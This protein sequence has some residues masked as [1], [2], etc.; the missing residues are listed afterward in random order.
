MFEIEVAKKDDLESLVALLGL[1][2]SKEAEF[3]PDPTLQRAGLEMILEDAT[4]GVIFVLK[5]GNQSI[6]MV[7]LLWTISTALG[8]KVA[9]LEDMMIHPSWQGK[10]GGSMLLAH[11]VSYAKTFT[12]KRITLLSDTDN[13]DAHRF[14]ERFGFTPSLMQ[15]M[16]LVLS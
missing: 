6:G 14:Y 3:A 9:L 10:G 13:H 11:A 7:S 1:L 8:G 5:E 2:F 15:P 4:Q 12:C 16:R